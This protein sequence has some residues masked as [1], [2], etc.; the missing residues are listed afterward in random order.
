[1]KESRYGKVKVRGDR[2]DGRMDAAIEWGTQA[3]DVGG[4]ND[5]IGG[6]DNVFFDAIDGSVAGRAGNGGDE[7]VLDGEEA[8]DTGGG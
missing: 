5:V 1:M 3:A 6:D 7:G 4:D 2:Y 8:E